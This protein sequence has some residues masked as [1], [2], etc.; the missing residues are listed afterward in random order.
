MAIEPTEKRQELSESTVRKHEQLRLKPYS[1]K[2][3]ED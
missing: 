3:R 2:Q 1:N